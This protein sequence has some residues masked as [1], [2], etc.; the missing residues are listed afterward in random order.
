MC[1]VQSRHSGRIPAPCAAPS[2][3]A[4][5]SQVF[6]IPLSSPAASFCSSTPA[7][8]P[9]ASTAKRLSALSQQTT[10]L[11]PQSA[12]SHHCRYRAGPSQALG[13]SPGPDDGTWAAPGRPATRTLTS[14]S[15]CF[16]ICTMGIIVTRAQAAHQQHDASATQDD[17]VT[18][19]PVR[20]FPGAVQV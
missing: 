5:L 2:L 8:S 20:S 9:A 13:L 11:T 17:K 7:V 1:L 15:L 16:P 12:Y 19:K 14:L 10:P 18:L 6:C 3:A 4:L